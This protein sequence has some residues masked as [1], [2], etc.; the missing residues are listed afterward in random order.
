MYT[1]CSQFY[2][3]MGRGRGPGLN[4]LLTSADA[5]RGTCGCTKIIIVC[6]ILVLNGVAEA[7]LL[8]TVHVMSFG[9][10]TCFL[11]ARCGSG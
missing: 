3:G 6:R 10:H 1:R 9:A 5:V 2:V 11:G 8:M 4:L 7:A